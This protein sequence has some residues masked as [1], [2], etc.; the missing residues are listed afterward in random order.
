[1]GDVVL[2][3]G[4]PVQVGDKSS[5]LAKGEV[6]GGYPGA[7]EMQKGFKVG[8][9]GYVLTGMHGETGILQGTDSTGDRF[10]AAGKAGK[11]KAKYLH[12]ESL[13]DTVLLHRRE[14]AFIVEP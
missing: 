5:R 2:P 1:M 8:K 11:I 14:H 6:K 13:L 12:R 4:G 7:R 10:S 9:A 3:G